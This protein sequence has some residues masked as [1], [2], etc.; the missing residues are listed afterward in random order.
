MNITKQIVLSILLVI[1]LGVNI[2]TMRIIS[3][4]KLR[5]NPINRHLWCLNVIDLAT[6]ISYIPSLWLEES[7]KQSEYY[8]AFYKAYIKSNIIYYGKFLTLYIL[9]NLTIDR[10][11]G[12][13]KKDLHRTMLKYSKTRL[14]LIWI[15]VTISMIPAIIYSRIEII[16]KIYEARSI[17]R[18]PVSE[19]IRIYKKYILTVMLCL[20]A[21]ALVLISSKIT[22]KVI[23]TTKKLRQ[24]SVYVRN[25]V[26]VLLCNISFV[27]IMML[28]GIILY[29]VN[30][31]S[32]CYVDNKTEMT[33][34][35]GQAIMLSWSI[36]NMLSF[37]TLCHEYNKSAK[38]V[39]RKFRFS[40]GLSLAQVPIAHLANKWKMNRAYEG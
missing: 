12:I 27:G 15:L 7:C 24:R 22:I 2:V 37:M 6:L 38:E 31:K 28:V 4:K 5:K 29:R 9:L 30:Y 36:I 39:L 35:A 26:A 19:N 20:P 21:I 16:D 18:V 33:L 3:K 23:K 1:G 25:T 10:Y 17:T 40:E 11:M 14:I 34:L 13:C 8:K 32:N